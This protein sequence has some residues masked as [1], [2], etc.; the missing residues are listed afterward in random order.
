[1]AI[2]ENNVREKA[3]A[4]K[5]E[6]IRQTDSAG[7]IASAYALRDQPQEALKARSDYL[8]KTGF[9]KRLLVDNVAIFSSIAVSKAAGWLLKQK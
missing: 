8:T 6:E 1:M 4:G 7:S 5:I 2:F 3:R 9:N